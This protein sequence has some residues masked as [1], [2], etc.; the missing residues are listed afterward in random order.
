MIIL[1]RRHTFQGGEPGVRLL[2]EILDPNILRSN[3]N[4][5]LAS[6]P[7]FQEKLYKGKFSVPYESLEKYHYDVK[8]ATGTVR[9][10]KAVING[11]KLNI[12][13]IAWDLQDIIP[14][15][16]PS[17]CRPRLEVLFSGDDVVK[18]GSSDIEIETYG[19]D[20]K[21]IRSHVPRDIDGGDGNDYILTHTSD[22]LKG[23]AGEDVFHSLL[24]PMERLF[25]ILRLAKIG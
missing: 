1:I 12:K 10:I 7:T 9:S 13:K 11:E 2:E 19:G 18:A 16:F 24:L 6:Q 3:Q 5:F 20:D 23:G 25:M 21:I 15:E 8:N 17:N 14:C 4:L 22:R